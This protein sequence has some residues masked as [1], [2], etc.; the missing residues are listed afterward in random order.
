MLGFPTL[1]LRGRRIVMF[2]HSGLYYISQSL[3][4][5][6]ELCF[7]YYSAIRSPGFQV[8]GVRSP[9]REVVA[10]PS[11]GHAFR[12]FGFGVVGFRALGFR[13]LGVEGIEVWAQRFGCKGLASGLGS[14]VEPS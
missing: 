5:L 14:R 11:P 6:Q 10:E 3:E 7:D 2:Q 13:G 8:S 1:Y 4:S 9:V 12:P